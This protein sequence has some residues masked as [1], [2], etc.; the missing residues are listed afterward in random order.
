MP[1]AVS[2]ASTRCW[3]PP[4]A[5]GWSSTTPAPGRTARARTVTRA[6]GHGRITTAGGAAVA[7]TADVTTVEGA[8]S[9]LDTALGS[10]GEVHGLVNNAGVLRDRMFVNMSE[11][12][13]DDVITG[14]CGHVRAVSRVRRALARPVEA[15]DDVKAS[16]VN[17]SSTSGCSARSAEQYGA[18]K[19]GSRRSPDPRAGVGALRDSCQR[20]TPV[21]RT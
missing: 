2:V 5:P 4:R 12:E 20:I 10:F 14:S 7:N 6:S 17:V 15:G 19:A 11:D 21:A 3:P 1:V 13:W 18:A 9:L 8:Q 16:I